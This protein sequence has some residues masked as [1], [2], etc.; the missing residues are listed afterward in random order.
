[1]PKKTDAT[2]ASEPIDEQLPID[3]KLDPKPGDKDYD[4]VTEYGTGD[5]YTHTLPNGKVVA[6]KAFGSIFSKTWL[7]KIRHLK[8]NVDVELAAIDRGTCDTAKQ[9]LEDLDDTGDSDPIADLWKA[10]TEG[11]AADEGITSG[12]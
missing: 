3:P 8:T 12:N 6:L 4:W 5:I 11:G 2:T 10:W 1:M 7:F 9:L